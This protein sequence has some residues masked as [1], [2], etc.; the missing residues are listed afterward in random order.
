M[1]GLPKGIDPAYGLPENRPSHDSPHVNMVIVITSEQRPYSRVAVPR[2]RSRPAH[3]I[4]RGFHFAA[5]TFVIL[6]TTVTTVA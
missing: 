2:V 6:V 3:T 4:D 1:L 5:Q